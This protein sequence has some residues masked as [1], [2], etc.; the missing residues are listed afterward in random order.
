MTEDEIISVEIDDAGRLCVQ[1]RLGDFSHIYRAASG[2]TWDAKRH[3]LMAPQPREWTYS[4][5]LHQIVAD[6]ANE[7]G[8]HLT[9]NHRTRWTGVPPELRALMTEP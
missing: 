8:V 7:Y 4:M 5:W 6:T 2:V 1:P 3:C 9:L